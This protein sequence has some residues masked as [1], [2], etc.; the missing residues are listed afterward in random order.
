M[1]KHMHLY[2][3]IIPI[4]GGFHKLPVFQRVLFKRYNCLGLQDWLADLRTIAIGSASQPFEGRHYYRSMRLHKERF[5][6]LVQRRVEDATNK[7][8]LIYLHL[9][10]NLSNLGKDLPVKF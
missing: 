3:K 10:S 8:E 7:F 2:S 4:M 6:A 5:D 1:W 9:L